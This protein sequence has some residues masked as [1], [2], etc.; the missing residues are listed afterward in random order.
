MSSEPVL[1]ALLSPSLEIGRSEGKLIEVYTNR[2]FELDRESIYG[3]FYE[4]ADRILQGLPRAEQKA[5]FVLGAWRTAPPEH[6]A[7]WA[8]HMPATYRGS[9]LNAAVLRVLKHVIATSAGL[10]PD[11]IRSTLEH[12]NPLGSALGSLEGEAEGAELTSAVRE[13]LEGNE[14]W[15][16]EDAAAAQVPLH[17]LVRAIERATPRLAESS[18]SDTNPLSTTRFEDINRA[19][20]QQPWELDGMLKLA[21]DLSVENYAELWERVP[22]ADVETQPALFAERVLALVTLEQRERGTNA[23]RALVS[24]YMKE[25]S[26]LF[27]LGA[28]Y[29]GKVREVAIVAIDLQP[30]PYQ[31]A[32]LSRY[33]GS[34]PGDRA[35]SAVGRWAER[36][37]RKDLTDALTR[38][39]RPLFDGTNWVAALS[40]FDYTEAPVFRALSNALLEPGTKV[41]QRVRMAGMTRSLRIRTQSGRNKLA[42]LIAT[43]LGTKRPKEDLRVVLVLCE[44]LGPE[45]QRHSKLQ[46]AFLAYAKRH[47]HKFTPSEVPAIAGIGVV[48]PDKYLSK[49]AVKRSKDLVAE[50]IQKVRQLG[51]FVGLGT[52]K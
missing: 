31:L 45:H 43:L 29:R 18:K 5:R 41:G 30:R 11:A 48:L 47:T 12:L 38:M 37:E 27:E 22:S 24:Q 4:N 44:G 2:L 8:G 33:L 14:W 39:I 20:L 49:N 7:D 40:Q 51:K 25:I 36:S 42:D 46:K 19:P 6:W 10:E 26:A 52:A 9:G 34:S 32:Q 1:D 28:D 23:S 3:Y 21:V 13:A 15:S 50:G 35:L 17:E 16:E